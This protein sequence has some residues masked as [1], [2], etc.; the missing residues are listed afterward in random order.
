[1]GAQIKT[2]ITQLL[3][4]PHENMQLAKFCLGTRMALVT[5]LTFVPT[6]SETAS[7]KYGIHYHHQGETY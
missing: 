7:G 2:I 5:F 4:P 6:L 1:M 3:L